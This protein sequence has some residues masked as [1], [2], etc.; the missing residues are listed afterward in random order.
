M[1][2]V[3]G[4]ASVRMQQ[5]SVGE[6]QYASRCNLKHTIGSYEANIWE[7]ANGAIACAPTQR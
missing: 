4:R 5:A 3:D 7:G 6:G 1:A 2:L